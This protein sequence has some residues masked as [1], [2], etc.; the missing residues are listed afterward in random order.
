MLIGVSAKSSSLNINPNE[1]I[2]YGIQNLLSPNLIFIGIILMFAA[3]MSSADS[4]I[5]ILASNFVKDFIV[6]LRNIKISKEKEI[7]YIKYF[8]LL[9]S[10]LIFLLAYFI[11]DLVYISL[12]NIG[13]GVSLTP[14]IYS[15]IN[16]KPNIKAIIDSVISGVV[17]VF[18]LAYLGLVTP[19]WMLST[20]LVS[21]VVLV[22]SSKIRN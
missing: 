7:I 2:I 19:Q 20:V 12:L 14:A 3:I 11:R 1:V 18:I 15:V 17:Y 5:F 13:L 16:F 10:V 21:T 22:F 9:F 6:P 8:I 4:Y